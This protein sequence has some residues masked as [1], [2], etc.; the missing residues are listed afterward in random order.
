MPNAETPNVETPAVQPESTPETPPE[1]AGG[2][3]EKS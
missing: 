1:P 3:E 2:T